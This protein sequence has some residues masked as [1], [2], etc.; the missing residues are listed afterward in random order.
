MRLIYSLTDKFCLQSNIKIQCRRLEL[1]LQD[2]KQRMETTKQRLAA[3]K[4]VRYFS[5]SRVNRIS[6]G[7]HVNTIQNMVFSFPKAHKTVIAE[8]RSLRKEVME[9]KIACT[10]AR[11]PSVG[12]NS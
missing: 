9:T 12:I 2:L 5:F 6:D 10:R 11:G 7:L 8:C 1:S 4:E 3:E